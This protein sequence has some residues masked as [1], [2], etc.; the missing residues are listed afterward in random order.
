MRYVRAQ[1]FGKGC[2]NRQEEAQSNSS[3]EV[4][5]NPSENIWGKSVI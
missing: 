2:W 5:H 3:V 4:M 1:K